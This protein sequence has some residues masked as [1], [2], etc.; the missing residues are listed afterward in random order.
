MRGQEA[1]QGDP[2]VPA[3]ALPGPLAHLA[4]DPLL[5]RQG[6]ARGEEPPGGLPPG[7]GGRRGLQGRGQAAHHRAVLL[8]GPGQ[9][10]E[11]GPPVARDTY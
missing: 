11:A 1:A 2:G 10:R 8:R 6:G 9:H 4:L 7:G 5:L 3:A